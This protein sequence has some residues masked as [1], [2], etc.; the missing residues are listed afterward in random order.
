MKKFRLAIMVALVILLVGC[1]NENPETPND[2]ITIDPNSELVRDLNLNYGPNFYNLT[3]STECYALSIVLDANN[4]LEATVQMRAWA[5]EY[6]NCETK[7]DLH[8]KI[9]GEEHTAS[10][11]DFFEWMGFGVP[12]KRAQRTRT[13]CR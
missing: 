12:S 5:K 11:E 7:A 8:V 10:F 9:G 4:I 6:G 13:S 2:I 3:T 1:E